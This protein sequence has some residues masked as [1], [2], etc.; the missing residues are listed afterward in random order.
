MAGR[1]G[2]L[3]KNVCWPEHQ[4]KSDYDAWFGAMRNA[5]ENFARLWMA[6]WFA[7]LEHT[8]GTLNR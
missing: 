8:P 2:W 1:C 6:P 7:G 5:G 3:V 4:V